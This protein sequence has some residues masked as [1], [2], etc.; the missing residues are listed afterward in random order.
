MRPSGFC[1]GYEHELADDGVVE[2]E[3]ELDRVFGVGR[4]RGRKPT[5]EDRLIA[6]M[7]APWLDREIADG[8][9]MSL[10]EAHA[11]RAEQLTGQRSRRAVARSLDRLVGRMNDPRPGL[12]TATGRPCRE[13]VLEVMPLIVSIRACLRSTQPLNAHGVARSKALLRNREG[14]CYVSDAP[15]ELRAALRAVSDSLAPAS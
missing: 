2:A 14:P 10:S 11:A 8:V 4:A 1:T 6:R 5:L 3:C 12:P 9:G 13:Q 7:L 15:A